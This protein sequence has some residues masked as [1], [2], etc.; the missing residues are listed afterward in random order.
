MTSIYPVIAER[1]DQ[2]LLPGHVGYA[3]VEHKYTLSAAAVVVVVFADF[4]IR[5]VKF[6]KAINAFWTFC[7]AGQMGVARET[8]S[9][10]IQWL[11]VANIYHIAY[12][13]YINTY[14]PWYK[15]VLPIN[16][17]N[18]TDTIY[19][20]HT[21]TRPTS[22]NMYACVCVCVCIQIISQNYI[23]IYS[24]FAIYFFCR[25]IYDLYFG[26]IYLV[27]FCSSLLSEIV[28]PFISTCF[29]HGR[30]AGQ[31]QVRKEL[32]GN[33]RSKRLIDRLLNG[34]HIRRLLEGTGQSPR[35]ARRKKQ[36]KSN[37]FSFV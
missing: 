3:L 28:F 30:G 19:Q 8:Y 29:P 15:Q 1:L 27:S 37:K 36:K 32:Y 9:S 2:A 23:Y 13:I 14:V 7:G 24:S 4:M 16:N 12:I 25:V 20:A 34:S 18:T 22:H 17:T 10:S 5:L 35:P 26:L 33:C 21:L 6:Q 31:R 11:L